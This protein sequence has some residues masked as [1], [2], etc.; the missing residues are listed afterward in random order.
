MFWTPV[1]EFMWSGKERKPNNTGGFVKMKKVVLLYEIRLE[2]LKCSVSV[3][4]I[5]HSFPSQS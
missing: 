5:D 3:L 1:K 4:G 2:R